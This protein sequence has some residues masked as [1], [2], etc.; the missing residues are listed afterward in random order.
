MASG[1]Y[2]ENQ[3]EINTLEDFGLIGRH[4][5]SLLAC[6]VVKDREGNLV[7]LVKVRNPWGNFEWKGNWSDESECW[8]EEAKK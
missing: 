4:A 1:V 7:K 6:A 8:T 2:P 3:Q 5:Y